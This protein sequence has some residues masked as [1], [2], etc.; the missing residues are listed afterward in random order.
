M[1]Y[2]ESKLKIIYTLHIIYKIEIR[3]LYLLYF[4]VLFKCSPSIFTMLYVSIHTTS[5]LPANISDNSAKI[6]WLFVLKLWELVIDIKKR[7]L[8]NLI[9]TCCWTKLCCSYRN[10]RILYVFPLISSYFSYKFP[11]FISIF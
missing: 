3:N 7:F 8:N 5:K 4:L 1:L 6:I 2:G 10:V 9:F 11:D